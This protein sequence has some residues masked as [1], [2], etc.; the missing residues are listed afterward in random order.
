[1]E[2]VGKCSMLLI[3]FQQSEVLLF[4]RVSFAPGCA[5][6][7]KIRKEILEERKLE[8][9]VDLRAEQILFACIFGIHDVNKSDIKWT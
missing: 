7:W 5:A 1:M 8:L 4:F 9:Q 6:L 3:V 2:H